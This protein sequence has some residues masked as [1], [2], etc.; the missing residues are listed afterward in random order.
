MEP[1]V[2][3]EPAESSIAWLD[4]ELVDVQT[5]E[6]FRISDFRGRPVLVKAFAV[7]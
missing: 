3:D 4:S 1:P 6:T 2:P 7:W 5:G